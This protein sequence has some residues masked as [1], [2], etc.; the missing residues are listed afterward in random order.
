MNTILVGTLTVAAFIVIIMGGVL[1]AVLLSYWIYRLIASARE[2]ASAAVRNT[3]E[4]MH[5]RSDFE[6]YKKDVARWDEYQRKHIEKCQ[7]CKYRRKAMEENNNMQKDKG[8]KRN[9]E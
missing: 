4:Y 7:R 9:D 1:M 5:C 6:L 2:R 8:V 3:K